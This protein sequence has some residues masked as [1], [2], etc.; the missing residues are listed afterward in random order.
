M[1]AYLDDALDAE[2]AAAFEADLARDPELRARF[3]ALSGVDALVR[4]AFAA[5]AGEPVPERFAKLLAADQGDQRPVIDL[6][7][8]RAARA[9]KPGRGI[10]QGWRTA[11]AAALALAIGG[12]GGFFAGR[13]NILVETYLRL[14]AGAIDKSNPLHRLLS[15]A[16]SGAPQM[17]SGGDSFAPVLTFIAADGRPCREFELSA[18]AATAVGLACRDNGGWRLEALLAAAD[19]PVGAG[20]AP[21]SGFSQAALEAAL[22]NLGAGAPLGPEEE[23]ALIAAGWTR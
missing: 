1:S 16:P 10:G 13:E 5:P 6:A 2:A 21:A 11:A 8:F 14:E 15:Q 3:E 22:D 4:E 23:Q 7:S 9:V 17:I 19:R 12:G 20:Y 18:D